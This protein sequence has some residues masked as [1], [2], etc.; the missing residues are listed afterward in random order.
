M[1]LTFT[2][3]PCFSSGLPHELL[4]R[5][6]TKFLLSSE[7]LPV[8]YLGLP[9]CSKKLT[10]EDCDPLIS[11]IRRKPNGWL[12]RRLSLAGRLRLISTVISGIVGFWTSAFLL[13]KRVKQLINSLTTSFLWKGTLDN[14]NGAKVAWDA[15][16]FPKSEGG[17]GLRRLSSWNAIFSL[18]LIWFLFFRSGSLWVAWCRHKYLSNGSFWSLN[19]KNYSIS[20]TF[21]RLLK[22]RILALPFLR[23]NVGRGDDTFFW[24]DPWT[25]IGP[26][27]TFLGASA[28]TQLG[29]LSDSMVSDYIVNGSWNLPPARS[30]L[31]LRAMVYI[32]T[33][34]PS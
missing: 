11:Q 12:H 22:Y 15:L 10:I 4:D 14:S 1:R 16:C 31:H 25:S 5:I 8:R 29:I 34:I 23:I 21:R 13:P 24:Y 20:W 32:S 17:L 9:L 6:K 2:K 30:D 7:S 26:L 27:I 18:K 3:L 28:P 33:V 19:E